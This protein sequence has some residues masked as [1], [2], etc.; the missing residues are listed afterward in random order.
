MSKNILNI[1]IKS[2]RHLASKQNNINFSDVNIKDQYLLCWH[3]NLDWQSSYHGI[4]H[5]MYFLS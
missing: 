5:Q 4:R 3:I 1:E 2:P